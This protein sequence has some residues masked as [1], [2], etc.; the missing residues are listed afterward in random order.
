LHRQAD[1]P[2]TAVSPC[3]RDDCRD[4]P[5]ATAADRDHKRQM[6]E[7]YRALVAAGLVTPRQKQ[8]VDMVLVAEFLRLRG[9]DPAE[10]G[11]ALLTRLQDDLDDCGRVEVTPEFVLLMDR[12][13]M[14]LAVEEEAAQMMTDGDDPLGRGIGLV[15]ADHFP[16]AIR[17]FSEAIESGRYGPETYWHR[18]RAF[19]LAGDNR[20]AILDFDRYLAT[21][22]PWRRPTTFAWRAEALMVEGQTAETIRSLSDAV[23]AVDTQYDHFRQVDPS[24]E[25]GLEDVCVELRAVLSIVECLE[26]A[27]VATPSSDRGLGQAKA[28]IERL[29]Q[30]IGTRP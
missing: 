8:K 9:A 4:I 5:T 14:D 20:H 22:A 12:R 24:D 13:M 23:A 3:L 11:L 7:V 27:R 16:E 28:D 17:A 6:A 29:Q 26:G 30:R 21:G 18:G 19:Q 10:D 2:A 15:L 1:C 25:Q